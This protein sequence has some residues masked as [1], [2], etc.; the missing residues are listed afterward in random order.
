MGT[1]GVTEGQ[2]SRLRLRQGE[3]AWRREHFGFVL[4]DRRTDELYEGN[5]VGCEILQRLDEGAATD[6]IV[7]AIEAR[8]AVT[9]DA[10]A[11]D[12][13]EFIRCLLL[14]DLVVLW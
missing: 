3:V 4:Y 13:G 1:S 2:P 8:Y 10:A 7:A 6:E 12:I 5:R 14:N 11:G 9:R